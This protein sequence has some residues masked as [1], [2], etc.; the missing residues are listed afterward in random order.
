MYVLTVVYGSRND[1]LRI[2]FIEL[3]SNVTEV[4]IQ[5]VNLIYFLFISYVDII[6]S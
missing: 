2:R 3:R 6:H 5:C 1:I 4:F